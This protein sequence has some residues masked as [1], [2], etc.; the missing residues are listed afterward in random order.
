MITSGNDQS[1]AVRCVKHG[2]NAGGVFFR[3]EPYEGGCA[4]YI[5]LHC[6]MDAGE[7]MQLARHEFE[8]IRYQVP[9]RVAK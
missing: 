6:W 1:A 8:A 4:D 5:C 2:R 3:P 7:P 9:A